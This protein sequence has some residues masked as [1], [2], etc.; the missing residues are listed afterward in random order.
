VGSKKIGDLANVEGTIQVGK[1]EKCPICGM[2]V[3]KY[4]R[5]AT[6]IFYKKDSK[7]GHYSFDGVKDLMKFY[8]DP[9]AWGNFEVKDKRDITKI[10][11]TD[12]YTQKGIDAKKAYFVLG[13]NVYGPMGDELIPF[14]NEDDAKTFKEDHRGKEVLKFEE[15]T[16]QGV[17]KLDE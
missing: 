6:Q 10:L 9:K 14:E 12:Y 1:D 11:V 7:E 8:F 5:W 4:P 15:I 3:Y 2:F 16:S 17:Y 13:S